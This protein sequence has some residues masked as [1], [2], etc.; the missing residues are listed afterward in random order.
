MEFEKVVDGLM[1]YLDREI[2]SA[3]ND[4]QDVL[5]R[6]AVARI[7]G[8]PAKLKQQL[9]DN[10]FL[11]TFAIIDSKG[12]VDIEG[13][14]PELQAQI[15]KK[16]KIEITIPMFGKFCFTEADVQLLQKYIMEG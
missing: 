13:I 6:M 12:M 10:S 16:Q 4:W 1:K 14:M 11:R 2:F 9:M 5:A 7:A 15:K 8:N 3:M